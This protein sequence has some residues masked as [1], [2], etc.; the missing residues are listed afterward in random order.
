MQKTKGKIQG[1]T[2]AIQTILVSLRDFFGFCWIA[3]VENST[4]LLCFWCCWNQSFT[5]VL[6]QFPIDSAQETYSHSSLPCETCAKKVWS[7]AVY[8][9]QNHKPTAQLPEFDSTWKHVQNWLNACMFWAAD[10]SISSTPLRALGECMH[11]LF[12]TWLKQL[13]HNKYYSDEIADQLSLLAHWCHVIGKLTIQVRHA[14][15]PKGAGVR[16]FLE[17]KIQFHAWVHAKIKGIS[18]V[19]ASKNCWSWCKPKLLKLVQTKTA[20]VGAFTKGIT[21]KSSNITQSLLSF[22]VLWLFLQR[23]GKPSCSVIP[24]NR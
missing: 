12:W 22:S 6:L 4:L 10:G 18:Q 8:L 14:K 5:S 21:N 19:P 9:Q 17:N 1:G 7:R 23:A 11:P 15:F 16:L 20:E 3:S 13:T 24:K 2:L